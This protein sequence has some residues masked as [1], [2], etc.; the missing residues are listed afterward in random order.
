MFSP[1]LKR[2]FYRNRDIHLPTLREK[3]RIDS[4]IRSSIQREITTEVHLHP[5]L[6]AS[7]S[8]VKGL[9]SRP[10]LLSQT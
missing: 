1:L 4:L 9:P 6:S 10:F 7:F 2:N 5:L 3:I 8:G